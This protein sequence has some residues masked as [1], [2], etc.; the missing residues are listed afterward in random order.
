MKIAAGLG[1]LDQYIPYVKAG[2]DELFCGYVPEEWALSHGTMTPLNRREVLYCNVQL[3]SQSELEI[4]KNMMDYYGVPV[5][6][7]LNSLYYLPSQYTFLEELILKCRDLGFTSFILA[8]PALLLYL[9]QK[10][11]S[12]CR[13]HLSGETGEVNHLMVEEM[14]S[15]GISR[16]I[17]HRKNTIPDM[18]ECIEQ[19]K[20]LHPDDPLEY[21]AFVLNEMCHFTGGFCN[22]LHCDELAHICRVPYILGGCRENKTLEEPETSPEPEGYLTGQSGCGLCALWQLDLAGIT[23]AKLVSRGNYR[24]D[25]IQDISKLRLALKILEQSDSR[26]AYVRDMKKQ[27]FDGPC[28]KRCYYPVTEYNGI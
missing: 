5:T 8:D 13:F 24:E 4:L 15:F 16:V 14:R 19:E 1:S 9:H 6:I 17:F 12:G 23:H 22:S 2:A 11:I 26:E 3:G 7:T 21:E 27:V 28:S 10:K 25:T 20:S 18:Q